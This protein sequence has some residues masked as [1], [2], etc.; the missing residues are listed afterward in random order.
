MIGGGDPGMCWHV[1][2]SSS[3]ES[4]RLCLRS[5]AQCQTLPQWLCTF[6]LAMRCGGILSAVFVGLGWLVQMVAAYMTI[7]EDIISSELYQRVCSVPL[8]CLCGC[9]HLGSSMMHIDDC[10]AGLERHREGGA[11]A[12]RDTPPDD[13]S[14]FRVF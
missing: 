4:F 9:L 13:S 2:G 8:G 7:N 1:C 5:L 3:T 14:S 12:V 10:C 11:E 6:A